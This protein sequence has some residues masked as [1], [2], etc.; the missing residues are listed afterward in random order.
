MT[1]RAAGTIGPPALPS[2]ADTMRTGSWRLAALLAAGLLTT[3]GCGSKAHRLSGTVNFD[4]KP[5]PLGRIYF[6]PDSTKENTGPS[7]FT[8]IVD[9]EYDTAIKGKGVTGG[10]T[11]VRILGF[12]KEG[13]DSSGFGPPLFQEYTLQVDLPVADSTRNFDVPASAAKGLPKVTAPLDGPP[14]PGTK[15]GT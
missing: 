13:A 1:N 14:N 5:L 6:D 2:E 10:P 8:D 9:G 12:K 3:A 7:G 15:G 11:V 4:G